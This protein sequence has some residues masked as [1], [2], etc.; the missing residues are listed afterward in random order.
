MH[1]RLRSVPRPMLQALWNLR[2]LA[3]FLLG[4]MLGIA[5]VEAIFGMPPGLYLLAAGMFVVSLATLLALVN[6]E[7]RRIIALA[8]RAGRSQQRDSQ[9]ILR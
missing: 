3:L 6:A 1:T 5:L 8:C 4:P 9:V 2:A 7:R